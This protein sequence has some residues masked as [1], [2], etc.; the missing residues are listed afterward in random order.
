MRFID[1]LVNRE[2]ERLEFAVDDDQGNHVIFIPL[3]RV[4]EEEYSV[5]MKE[6]SNLAGVNRLI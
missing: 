4:E 1:K 5:Y 3:F 6:T 2:K